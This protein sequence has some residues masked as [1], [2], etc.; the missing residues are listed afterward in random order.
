MVTRRKRTSLQREQERLQ[1]LVRA[2]Y[3]GL[4]ESALDLDFP[5]PLI[6]TVLEDVENPHVHL[7]K[8]FRNPKYLAFTAEHVFNIKLHPFQIVILNELWFRKYP[9]LIATRGGGKSFILALYAMM[10][11]FINQGSK[12]VI[13]G[14]AFRQAKVIFEYCETI[15]NNAPI[16]RDIV[17][18]GVRS[19]PR[20]DVDRC[21]CTLGDSIITALP[22]GDG[23]KIRGQRANIIIADEFASV[24]KEVFDTVVHGFGSVNT[25]P[26]ESM[27]RAARIRVLKRKGKWS[28]AQEE[29][30]AKINRGTQSIISGT[31][32]YS[33][34]HFADQ[35]KE[36]KAVIESKGDMR[37]IAE[38]YHGRIPP[39]FNYRHYSI[40]RLPYELL[41]E[42]FLDEEHIARSQ[43]T[44]AVGSHMV[45]YG[46][47]F[48][49]DSNGFFPRSLIES[50]VVRDDNLQNMRNGVSKFQAKLKGDRDKEYI[51]AID[52]ASE[53]DNFVIL[54]LELHEGHRRVVFCWS[55]TRQ[56]HLQ[57]IKQ[58]YVT[59]QNFYGY[60][61]RK[62][63]DL[64]KVF[65]CR[66]IIMDAQGG[67]RTIAETL[68]DADK[69]QSGEELIWETVVEDDKKDSDDKA[70]LHILELANFSDAKW[71]SDANHGLKKDLQDKITLLPYFDPISLYDANQQDKEQKR[72]I[73][74][75]QGNEIQVTDTYEDIVMEIEAMKDEL[76]TIQHTQTSVQLRDHWD[77]PEIKGAGGRKGRLRKDRYSSLLMGNMAA[78]LIQRAPVAAE[79]SS[80]GGFAKDMQKP[81][82]KDI[83]YTAPDW[84]NAVNNKF[85]YESYGIAVKKGSEV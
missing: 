1:K 56:K 30:E 4:D 76:V 16:L 36:Y 77:V 28:I 85:K 80:S 47:V 74:D 68:H 53:Q 60:C 49:G 35:W 6:P 63:R 45:E 10:K 44:S 58:G 21:T 78:R 40:I 9:M 17:G 18:I 8:I 42:G 83:L 64:M 29:A 20:R 79:Y 54:I 12:V 62:I 72:V 38:I 51:F 69:I 81:Q 55:T 26:V 11:S 52:T 65:R 73:I 19:G 14:S 15:W 61:A 22:L 13:V 23:T 27:E 75:K 37:K 2:E 70:G 84:F 43:L 34:N 71:V 39:K 31:A 82:T 48:A 25:S 66:H 24:P 41:P 5:N 3:L 32:Y 50:C 59:E 33:F 67:G 46:A 7:L 57:R